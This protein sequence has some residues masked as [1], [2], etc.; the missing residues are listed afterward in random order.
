MREP[1]EHVNNSASVLLAADRKLGKLTPEE[2]E[3]WEK[4]VRVDW[5]SEL[6]VCFECDVSR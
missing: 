4:Y 3:E 5:L 2:L 6:S 1:C